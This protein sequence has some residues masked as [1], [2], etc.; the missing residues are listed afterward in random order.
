MAYRNGT[1]IAFHADGTNVPIESDIKYYNLMKAWSAKKDDDFSMINSHEKTCAV[2]DN[3]LKETLRNRLKERLRNSKQMVLIIGKT[4][5][6]DND[7]VPFEIEYAVDVCNLP[8]IIV[9]PDYEYIMKPALL[10]HLWPV[11]L[12]E[13]IESGKVKA[14]H[15]PFKKEPLIDAMGQFDCN[16][17]PNTSLSYYTKEA[18]QQFGISI[19]LDN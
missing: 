10:S 7:W 12:K 5:R 14:I 11:K 18:Y 19:Q 1:Y 15:I 6:N 3:S 16:T 4:T 17:K 9:Y 8:L 2:R 13:R